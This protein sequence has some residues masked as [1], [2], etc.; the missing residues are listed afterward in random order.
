MS[1]NAIAG[2]GGI[3]TMRVLGEMAGHKLHILIDSGSTL[4]FIQEQ[5]AKK[6]GCSLVDSKPL[7]VRVANGQKMISTK[8]VANLQ[9]KM[10]DRNFAYSPRLLDNVGCDMILGGDWLKSCTPVELDYEGMSV[11]V[12][13]GGEKIKL[14]AITSL[15]DCHMISAPSLYK[16]FHS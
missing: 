9:W 2:E 6:L 11:T 10:Q 16:L 12:T 14:Q 13:K 5:T 15:S 4:S 1:L 7:L 3:T 8:Q